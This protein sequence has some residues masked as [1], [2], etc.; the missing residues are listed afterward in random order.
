[1]TRLRELPRRL[2]AVGYVDA[3]VA[4]GVLDLRAG[5]A[6]DLDALPPRT[7]AAVELFYLRREV[8]RARI[9]ATL[10]EDL[11]AELVALGILVARGDAVSTVELVALPV[12]GRI[13]LVP[14]P[15]RLPDA[16]FGDEVALLLAR[17]LAPERSALVLGAGPGALALQVAAT[18]P[19]VLAIEPDAV[20]FAC[21]E[22]N[23]AM[24][25]GALGARIELRAVA[26]DTP[27]EPAERF[28]RVIVAAP[29]TPLPAADD[30]AAVRRTGPAVL[31]RILTQLPALLDDDGLAQLV[32][33]LHG[34]DAGP[35]LPPEV[36]AA[37]RTH[38]LAITV[39]AVSR[40]PLAPGAPLFDA[41]TAGL[42]A[43]R[44]LD[45]QALRLAQQRF[46]SARG[47]TH[48]YLASIT[49][50]RAAT[51]GVELSR[52]WM[53]PGGAWQRRP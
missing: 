24:S 10:G 46:C 13:V 43:A 18:A 17:V 53:Q 40:A 25:G 36:S 31:A 1:M 49:A 32:G 39:T 12:F 3:L 22:L 41:F 7:A 42:A 27:L 23:V 34:G 35:T 20:A 26:L 44:S 48:L 52:H 6:A 28:E 4:R 37:A 51:G 2:V 9:S 30:E 11:V 38:G 14:S 19:R 50:A 45:P 15:G 33:V 29:T 47:I 8:A 5:V 21:A 16:Y